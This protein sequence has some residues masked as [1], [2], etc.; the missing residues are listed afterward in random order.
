MERLFNRI[1][2]TSYELI[3]WGSW[4]STA[5]NSSDIRTRKI[6]D[7]CVKSR[8]FHIDWQRSG[9]PLTRSPSEASKKR[10]RSGQ[11]TSLAEGG[12]EFDRNETENRVCKTA[13]SIS[14]HAVDV[15][16]P[17][18][19]SPF[20]RSRSSRITTT[21]LALDQSLINLSPVAFQYGD[22]LICLVRVRYTRRPLR[23]TS[24]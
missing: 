11:L 10:I 19:R 18:R 22:G 7:V 15:A 21:N 13:R 24:A 4:A 16:G 9:R 1:V 20:S 23:M 17:N 3:P 8:R 14:G 12:G 5:L 2:A 6:C